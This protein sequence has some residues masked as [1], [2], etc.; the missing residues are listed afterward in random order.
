MFL[1]LRFLVLWG[2]RIQHLFGNG[3]ALNPGLGGVRD[4][5]AAIIS[6][7]QTQSNRVCYFQTLDAVFPKDLFRLLRYQLP[8]SSMSYLCADLKTCEMLFG[9]AGLQNFWVDVLRIRKDLL[10]KLFSN[11]RKRFSRVCLDS[12]IVP[13]IY[14]DVK[15]KLFV[16]NVA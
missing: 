15:K 11:T 6:H 2:C 14:T 4:V 12:I 9:Q 13:N 1:F 3:V 10:G 7:E 5:A 8:I 16:K